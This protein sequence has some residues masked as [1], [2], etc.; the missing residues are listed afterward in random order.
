VR[1]LCSALLLPAILVLAGCTTSGPRP[2]PGPADTPERAAAELAAGLSKK[3]LAAVEFVGAT[4]AEVNALYQPLVKGMGPRK[5]DVTVN[6]VGRQGDSA[7]ATLNVVWTFPGVPQQW[8]YAAE[9]PLTNDGGRWKTNWR[10]NIVQ[11][12]L[13]GSNRLT[14]NRL[15]PERGELLGQDG[16]P[17]V[18]LRPVVRIGID[19]S[20]VAAG[21][22]DSSSRRL[23]RLVKIDPKAYAAK[24]AAAG[25][26]AFVEAIVLRATDPTRPPNKAVFAIDGALPIE[27]E[28]MLA[29][30]RDFARPIIG[31]VGQ[32]T[33]EIVDSSDGTVLAGDQVGLSGLQQRYDKSMRGTPGVRV[34]LV[35]AKQ[36]GSS[37]SPTPSPSPSP[38]A[39]A[40]RV[41]VFEVKPVAGK[42]LTTTLNIGLQTLAERILAKSKP[43]SALVAIRPSTGAVL[44]AANNA[45]T[46]GVS[47][48]TVGH[49]PPGSTF[50]VVSALA[51]LRAGL[52]PDS[53]V[54]CPRTVTVNGK[55]F[56]NYSD[57]PSGSF[58]QIPLQTALAQSCNTAFIGQRGRIKG[59][60][61]AEAAGSLGVGV[62]Y[63]TGFPSFF[64]SVPDDP[65]ATGRAASLIGQGKVEASPLAMAGVV[66]SVSAG[67][68]VLPH[69][70]EGQVP[71]S[72]AKPLTADEAA[73][74]RQMMRAV[75][76]QGSGRVLSGLG[77]TVIAKTGTAEYGTKTPYRTHAWM[78][79]GKGDLAVA[80]FVNEGESGS[81]TA[82]PLLRTFLSG[83]GQG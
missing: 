44:A 33:K 59:S 31:S 50:K 49:A 2:D 51:L 48:A 79:A 23:A 25:P 82:G 71:K 39:T 62:D 43:A 27:D 57:Y 6:G 12:Q 53:S 28:Q 69:L 17:I 35:A 73:Q 29:L 68:T 30:T 13:D 32:A 7:T 36:S 11:P 63:D 67:K 8:S 18:Q 15:D 40:K 64:G 77:G 76:T 20:R 19:K 78:I 37:A 47:I 55:T 26:A 14:Q 56:K 65:S 22:V 9:A 3:D 61:L 75:V 74:L 16:D 83:A 21:A 34:E 58:G 54:S 24:V 45:G 1:R 81:R 10:P 42:P 4:G 41:S 52:S 70:I 5:P 38:S 46:R 72:K 60:G 66:A 80:V